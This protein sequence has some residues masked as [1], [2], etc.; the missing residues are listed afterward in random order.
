MDE[1]DEAAAV[2]GIVADSLPAST[3]NGDVSAL[4]RIVATERNRL[5][6]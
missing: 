3:C 1:K 6:A 2:L 4:R 5:V